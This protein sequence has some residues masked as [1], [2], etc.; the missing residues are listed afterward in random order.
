MVLVAILLF[1]YTIPIRILFLC[2]LFWRKGNFYWNYYPYLFWNNCFSTWDLHT[3]FSS[4]LPV[5]GILW[6]L[7]GVRAWNWNWSISAS[8]AFLS[9][10][11]GIF[12]Q[13]GLSCLICMLLQWNSGSRGFALLWGIGPGCPWLEE[14]RHSW[15]TLSFLLNYH[16]KEFIKICPP[17]RNSTQSI[18]RQIKNAAQKVFMT[19]V[20]WRVYTLSSLTTARWRS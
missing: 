4:I 10:L 1:K 16:Q 6:V 3:F 18:I 11:A 9:C 5:C 14:M 8:P 19:M 17:T 7:S 20:W 13:A 15:L 2:L 12:L